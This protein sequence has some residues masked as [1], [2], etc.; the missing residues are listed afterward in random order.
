MYVYYTSLVIMTLF[1]ILTYAYYIPC[2]SHKLQYITNIYILCTN[3]YL[4]H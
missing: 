3:I 4:I 1:N 2:T